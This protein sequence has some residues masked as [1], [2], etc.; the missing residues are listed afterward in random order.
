M[1]SLRTLIAV[2][3]ILFIGSAYCM[4]QESRSTIIGR[5]TDQTGGVIPGVKVQALNEATN[6]G[7]SSITN[8]SGNYEI[9]YLLPGSYRVSAEMSGFKT[10]VRH[11]MELRVADRLTLDFG[12][13]IGELSQEVEVKGETPLLDSASASI[14]IIID[15][16]RITELPVVGGNPFYLARLSPGALSSGGRSAGNPM[17]YGAGTSII[18]NGT[19]DGSSEV[20][21]DGSPNMSERRGA[22]SPPQDLVLEFKIHTAT[23]DASIGHAAGAVTNVSMKSGTNKLHGT[24]YMFDSRLRAVPWFTNRYIHDPGTGPVTDAKKDKALEGWLHQRWGATVSGPVAIP[25]IYN[26]QNKTFWTFGYQGLHILRN[27]GFTGTVPT[28]AER[29]GDFSALLA[30]GAKYQIYDPATIAAAP[31]GRFSRQPLTGNIIPA[32]RLSP[33]AQKL[34]SYWPEP[35]VAGTADGRQNYYRTRDIIRDNRDFIARVDHN[36]SERHRIFARF[37]NNVYNNLA[38]TMPTIAVGDITDQTGYG[39]VF[40][41]VYVF[42]PRLLLNLRYGITYQNP[43]VSRVSQGFDLT[44]L[45]L[46]SSLMDEIRGKNDPVGLAFPEVVVDGTGGYTSLSTGGGNART[47]A[48]HTFGGTLTELTGAHSLRFGAEYRLMRENGFSYGNVAPRFEFSTNWTRGPLDNSPAAPLGQ[49]LASLMMGYP[50]GGRINTNASRAEQ[51]T[52]TSVFVHD[53]WKVTPRLTINIGLRYEYESPSTERFNRSIRSF[54]FN[55]ASPI[56]AAAL[57]NYQKAPIAEVPVSSFRTV[58]GLLF[59]G[60]GGQPRG[61]WNADNNNFAPRIGLAYKLTEKTILRAGYGIFYD[62]LGVDQTDVNQ[63]GFNQ[64]TTL[65][66]SLDNG[67]TWKATLSNPFPDGIRVPTGAAGGLATFLGQ[68]P[69]FFY[70]EVLN[71]YMQR[72]SFSVQRELPARMVIEASYVGNRGTK[73]P[74]TRELNAVPA[75]YL[76]TSPSRDQ[77]VINFLGEQVAN[78][79]Y[80]IPEFAGTTLGNKNVAR[81]QLLRPYPQFTGLSVTLPI[82]YSYYHSLQVAAEKR[83]AKGIS[84]QSSWTFSKFIESTTYLN[85][86]DPLPERVISDLDFTHRFVISTIYELP[87]GRGQALFGNA[88]GVV[89]YLIG[90]WQLQGHY[91]GQTGDAL[92]FGNAI[93]IGDLADIP[94]PLGERTAERWFNT[95]GV[96]EADSAKALASNIRTLP[97]RFN[98]IRGDGINNFDMSLFKNFRI[99]ETFKGQFRLE[100]FNTFNHVQFDVP[101]T[102]PTST[103]FGTITGEK[104]HGQRQLTFGLKLIF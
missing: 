2:S 13:E 52:F 100:T 80:G 96:F 89:N 17:D 77:N 92:G 101:N 82:G 1:R 14:G 3:S 70:E 66:P 8:D 37:N 47:T 60:T 4:A 86:S 98:K 45:G 46:P 26:G 30:L 102:T 93:L 6:T 19:R 28:L 33:V 44:T 56:S 29:K 85:E 68:A 103:A 58:G 12:L 42:N 36:F 84:F 87:F 81:S 78:P 95:D 41:D 43:V 9:P 65:I 62:V 61:L 76:S 18:V 31:K 88:G 20:T 91:E 27:L 55:T 64:P 49:G 22:F 51:S 57:T 53:D 38:Q 40:D 23:Y 10:S 69:S 75:Q 24:G 73:L 83:F 21:L 94:L 104:G 7:A 35:N 54:D 32:S 72:W 48:Y 99:S 59:A 71:P 39:A 15:E 5:V 67:L 79:F 25:H 34:V 63:G 90:G 74:V 50:T 11:H 97:T 16:K